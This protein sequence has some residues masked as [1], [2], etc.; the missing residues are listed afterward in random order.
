[1]LF[2]QGTR[3]EL[4]KWDLIEGVTSELSQATLHKLEGADHSFKA[5]KQNLIPA[6]ANTTR[7]WIDSINK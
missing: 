3:D 5:G 2:L 4:A 1:M 6:L 7:Q